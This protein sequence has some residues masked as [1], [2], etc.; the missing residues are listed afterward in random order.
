MVPNVWT[1]KGPAE[2]GPKVMH[3]SRGRKGSSAPK[4]ILNPGDGSHWTRSCHR[5]SRN[6][7]RGP[8]RGGYRTWG[9]AAPATERG[10]LKAPEVA[11]L[12]DPSL[13]EV[14]RSV[15]RHNVRLNRCI[16]ATPHSVEYQRVSREART[17]QGWGRG[18][19]V[20]A[21]I[22]K[23]ASSNMRPALAAGT[24]AMALSG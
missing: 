15:M 14:V 3:E 20:R 7:I 16:Y 8:R 23:T 6:L 2:A 4:Q 13:R 11:R 19:Q 18:R 5:K 17:G 12:N 1:R 9:Q 10:N 21:Q 22:L 24:A